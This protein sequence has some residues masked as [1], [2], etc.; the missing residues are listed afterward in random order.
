MYTFFY[1]FL[2][3]LGKYCIFVLLLLLL[4]LDYKFQLFLEVLY[5]LFF[6]V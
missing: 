5:E 4:L 1:I 3:V 6:V 2:I